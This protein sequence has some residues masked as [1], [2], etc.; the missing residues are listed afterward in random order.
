MSNELIINSRPYE[1]RVA[2]VDNGTVVELYIE[3]KTGQAL[4]GNIYRG[5][6]VRV[7]PGMQ[8]AFVDI[9][10]ERTGFLCVADV[11]HNVSGLAHTMRKHYMEPETASIEA[12]ESLQPD[13]INHIPF[14]IEELLHPNQDILVQ[15]AKEPLGKKGARLTSHISIPGRNLVLMPYVNH[16]G[17]SKKIASVDEKNRLKQIVMEIKPEETGF[18]VRTVSEGASQDKLKSDMDFLLK[19][20]E[21]IQYQMNNGTG[22]RLLYKDLSISLKAVRDLFTN[23]VDRLVIDSK[24][25]YNKIMAFISAFAGRLEHSVELYETPE[26]V[27]DFFG[28]EMDISRAMDDKVW[29]KSGGYIIIEHNEAI[30]TIDVNTGSYVGKRNRD[31]TFL[32]TNLEAIKEIAYQLRLRNIGGLIVIDFIDMNKESDRERVFSVLGETLR[33]DRA[34]ANILRMSELG[35]LEMTRKRTRPNLVKLLSEPCPYCNGRGRINSKQTICYEIFREI[36]REHAISPGDPSIRVLVNP[37]IENMLMEEEH[38]S[39]IFL[40]NRLNMKIIVTSK[41]DFHLE[42]YKIE[43]L[44][45]EKAV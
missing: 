34:S 29:L 37:I 7:L 45:A 20:W 31:E 10:I 5:K 36:E 4:R 3:R 30:T 44:V 13:R 18:I 12:P 11:Y 35:L 23:E 39:V 21:N 8:A 41:P 6:V 43:P 1:T 27:F 14:Q 38:E 28:I 2:L 15:V 17:V 26:P 19:L 9:G 42:Q 33:Q 25:E 40:E 24:P 22:P 32:K 16:V